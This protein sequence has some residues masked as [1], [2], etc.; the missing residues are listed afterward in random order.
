MRRT[1]EFAK[2]LRNREQEEVCQKKEK[3]LKGEIIL[4]IIKLLYYNG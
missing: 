2:S 1:K 4:K 3:N